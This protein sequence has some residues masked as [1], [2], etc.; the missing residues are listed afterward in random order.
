[1]KEVMTRVCR[2]ELTSN[3]AHASFILAREIKG[4][5]SCGIK[6]GAELCEFCFIVV[7]F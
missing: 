7:V 4:K 6:V 5:F 2:V 1:M 3:G